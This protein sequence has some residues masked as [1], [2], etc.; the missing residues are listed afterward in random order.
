MIVLGLRSRTS[1]PGKLASSGSIRRPEVSVE[2]VVL[3]AA[4]LLILGNIAFWRG[5]LAGRSLAE[6]WTWRFV[7]ATYCGLVAL[8]FFVLCLLATRYT[9]RP[10][11]CALIV[12]V[13][14]SGYF[15]HRYGVVL[16][17]QMLR[18]ALHADPQRRD[19]RSASP[20]RY[21]HTGDSKLAG[22]RPHRA[23]HR[24]PS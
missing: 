17:P 10:L 21:I 3:V 2:T 13:G 15:A 4:M 24:R 23:A 19:S 20:A 9:V 7:A 12:V 11:L 18:N 6:W 5:T 16:D 14:I 1:L 22:T 8:H